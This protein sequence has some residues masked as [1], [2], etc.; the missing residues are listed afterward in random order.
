MT[1]NQLDVNLN[2]VSVTVQNSNLHPDRIYEK[3]FATTMYIFTLFLLFREKYVNKERR[4][5]YI[6]VL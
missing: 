5:D 4:R 6:Y 3:I 2:T 1:T